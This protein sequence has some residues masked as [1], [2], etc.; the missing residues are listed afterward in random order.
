MKRH[1]HDWRRGFERIGKDL[2]RPIDQVYLQSTV[3]N[4]RRR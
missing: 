2:D 4:E 1:L 3:A